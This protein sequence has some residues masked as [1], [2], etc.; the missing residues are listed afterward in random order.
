MT[1]PVSVAFLVEI[2]RRMEEQAAATLFHPPDEQLAL[3]IQIGIYQGLDR[4]K[5]LMESVLRDMYEKETR[6]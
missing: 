1:D 2:N 4:A 5:D 6:S 3:G